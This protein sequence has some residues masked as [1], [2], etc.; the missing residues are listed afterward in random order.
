MDRVSSVAKVSGLAIAAGVGV[1]V[2]SGHGVAAADTGKSGASDS[3]SKTTG[4][5]KTARS[6]RP[7]PKAA[8]AAETKQVAVAVPTAKRTTAQ[9][10]IAPPSVPTLP[11]APA[12]L[13]QLA[14]GARRELDRL[15]GKST[16]TAA[17]T[18]TPT[19]ESTTPPSDYAIA[20]I[21]NTPNGTYAIGATISV[22]VKFT[23]RTDVDTTNGTPTLSLFNGQ[24]LTYQA[25]SDGDTSLT[26]T[27][28]V[29]PGQNAS[30]LDYT[31]INALQLNGA[32]IS[33]HFD[34]T[35]AG[36]TLPSPGAANSLGSNADI[37]IDAVRP[38]A[39][40]TLSDSA[41]KIGDT[42]T[43]TIAFSEKVT[44][45]SN[46]N[47]STPNATLGTLTTTDGGKIWTAT[48]TPNSLVQNTTQDVA[49]NVAGITDLAGNTVSGIVTPSYSVDTQAPSGVLSVGN[50]VLKAGQTTTL[51][52]T[53]NEVVSGFGIDKLLAT[54]ATIS[55]LSTTDGKTWTATL[56]PS[57]GVS[58]P[59][60]TA[61]GVADGITDA[62]GN[63][64]QMFAGTAYDVETIRPT[65]GVTLSKT[66]LKAGDTATVTFTFSEKVIGF[67]TADIAVAN[68]SLS[69]LSSADGG[70]TW[71]ATLTPAN[72]VTDDTNVITVDTAGVTDLAGNAGVGVVTSGNYSVRSA[73]P[74]VSVVVAKPH[75]GVGGTSAVTFTF[76]EA[77]TGF[78]NAD[79]TVANGTLSAVT[80]TDGGTTWTATLTPKAWVG[81]RT[82]VITVDTAGVTDAAGNAGVGVSASNNYAVD[83]TLAGW[84]RQ[85][86]QAFVYNLTHWS[87]G[88]GVGSPAPRPT[89][90]GSTL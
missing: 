24:V 38:S 64:L 50:N 12:L 43:V 72:G 47:V 9:L 68:G 52:I 32:T 13:E 87:D 1:A 45:F 77:V 86:I 71:T 21:P 63:P 5:K 44:G 23:H 39:I 62:A 74:T 53:F 85:S 28:V 48:L 49:I 75:L 69:A 6:A 7:A 73:R 56:T 33:D 80:T 36:L 65:V 70:L 2:A 67:T 89:T 41:L 22:D 18:A 10:R 8:A 84:V 60:N 25:G 15:T 4:P 34:G 58:A 14:A 55:N 78:T 16:S 29:Q 66:S 42:S 17:V 19:A 11:S 46:A 37:N 82:N 54:N 40:V 90:G 79:I 81:D 88:P 30:D 31:S 27:G 35:A 76:S 20:V 51:T 57:A 3:S 59:G 26:F 61:V 83:T